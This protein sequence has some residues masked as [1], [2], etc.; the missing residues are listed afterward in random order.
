MPRQTARRPAV[1]E[2]HSFV[3]QLR[4]TI[5]RDRVLTGAARTRRYRM[6]FRFGEGAALAVVRPRSLV[7]M[8]RALQ[9]C[10]AH[11]KIVIMQAANTGLTGGSTPSGDDYDRDVV[12]ISTTAM[13]KIHVIDEGRQVIC[14]AGATLYELEAAL[15]PYGR[16]PHSVIGSSCIG[17]SVLGGVCNNSG[18]ALVRRGPAFTELALFAQ[19]QA[20]GALRLVNHLGVDLGDGPEDMLERLD[21][22][23][24]GAVDIIGDAGRASDHDYATRVRDIAADTPA[25]FNADPQCLFE[26]SGSAGKL[27]VFA[28]RL[29]SFPKDE[30]SRVFYIGTNDPVELGDIR[31]AMLERFAELPIAAEYM[32]RDCFDIANEY[33]KSTFFAINLLGTERLPM[34]YTIGAKLSAIASRIGIGAD[35]LGPRLIHGLARLLPRHLPRRLTDYRDRYEHHL[36]LRMGG[37]GIAEAEA[38]LG[39][40]FPSARGDFFTCSPAEGEKAFLHRFAAA[41]AA[42]QYRKVHADAVAGI[43]ALDIALPRNSVNWVETL[44]PAIAAQIVHSL[45]YGH[46]FCHVFHQDYVLKKG[47]DVHALEQAMLDL[48]D[49]RGAEYPAEHG[50]GHL[51]E[52]KPALREFYRALDPCNSFNPG[53]GHSSKRAHW[54]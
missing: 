29:D 53:I 23:A 12:I 18:G 10:I 16:E 37:A 14:L 41:G 32:H 6:G 27:A 3:E 20:D 39:T 49:A 45:Y 25:R 1:P 44:P 40:I 2:Q 26:A 54:H 35:R 24:F 7:E 30:D 31:R 4:A 28:V 15:K 8:W 52:A 5:G 46:F 13:S 48:L 17:A 43:I 36:I 50:V 51:Y 19:R 11:E 9:L 42:I 22:G 34:L 21:R 33:G 38:Y 47:A